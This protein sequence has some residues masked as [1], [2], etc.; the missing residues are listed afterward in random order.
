MPDLDPEWLLWGRGE[1]LRA[2]NN[3]GH[4][5]E[6]SAVGAPGGSMDEPLGRW[7]MME[8]RIEA[9]ERE[10]SALKKGKG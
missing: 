9:L 6:A 4:L 8:R 3:N 1:M 5:A 10:V 2:K 7:E